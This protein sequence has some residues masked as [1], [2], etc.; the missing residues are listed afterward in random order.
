MAKRRPVSPPSEK[1]P[2]DIEMELLISA[3]KKMGEEDC[4]EEEFKDA[5][6]I[7]MTAGSRI[8]AKGLRGTFQGL[9]NAANNAQRV[10]GKNG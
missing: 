7:V 10:R 8:L 3:L 6:R 4:P 9:Y 1:T 2:A 5:F